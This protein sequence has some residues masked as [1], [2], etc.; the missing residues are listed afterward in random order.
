MIRSLF[1]GIKK[2]LDLWISD[3]NIIKLLVLLDPAG[4]GEVSKEI[5]AFKINM[6]IFADWGKSPNWTISK[7]NFLTGMVE[8]YKHNQRK[9]SAHVNPNFGKF[10]RPGISNEEFEELLLMYES[11]LSSYEIEKLFVE[12]LA[13]DPAAGGASFR[14]TCSIMS[15]YGFGFLR[16]FK[17]KELMAELSGRKNTIDV[18][19]NVPSEGSIHRKGRPS[20]H[21]KNKGLKTSR[22][23]LEIP[24]APEADEI[25]KF[26]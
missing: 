22:T 13:I 20:T 7:A 26:S 12:A 16:S 3:N 5:F 24:P 8:V 15:K 10:G 9:L 2:E 11:T 23:I 17:I 1:W 14:S 21:E 4:K 19:L 18:S 25:R 6:K